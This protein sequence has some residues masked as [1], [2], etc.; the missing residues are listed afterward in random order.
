MKNGMDDMPMPMPMPTMSMDMPMY[1]WSG[2][3]KYPL[4]WLLSDFTSSSSAAYAGGLVTVFVCGI[5][6]EGCTWLR[7]YVHIKTQIKAI[8]ATDALN[9]N[10]PRIIVDSSLAIKLALT[11]IYFAML[12]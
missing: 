1:F 3:D 2:Y 11:I 4:Y 9:P 6:I 7:N 12:V 5:I 10:V 8:E